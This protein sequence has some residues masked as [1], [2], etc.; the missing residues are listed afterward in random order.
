MLNLK[1]VSKIKLFLLSRLQRKPY[2][3]VAL[4]DSTVEGLGATNPEKAFAPLVH[5]A[6]KSHKK[7]TRFLNLG[8]AGAKVQDVL[9]FQLVEAIKIKTRLNLTLHRSK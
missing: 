3:I 4:G 2:V 5:E 6:I 9:N 8:V 7:N 1:I